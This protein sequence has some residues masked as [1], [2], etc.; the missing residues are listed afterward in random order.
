MIDQLRLASDAE[1]FHAA[2]A[3]IERWPIAFIA[4]PRD[5]YEGSWKTISSKAVEFMQTSPTF[6]S[7][8]ED[9]ERV[10]ALTCL[11]QGN[12][13]TT[14]LLPMAFREAIRRSTSFEQAFGYLQKYEF[15]PFAVLQ[16][17][18][19]VLIE[20]QATT[21]AH[22]NRL[23]DWMEHHVEH[24]LEEPE[25]L[26]LAEL[27]SALPSFATREE[28]SAF[29]M[30][31]LST[32]RTDQRLQ[33]YLA[34][35]WWDHLPQ[36]GA[37]IGFQELTRLAF[38]GQLNRNSAFWQR[39]I[40]EATQPIPIVAG[41]TIAF[42]AWY[43]T[44]YRLSPATIY[45][46]LRS[47]ALEGSEGLF[48]SAESRR[49]LLQELMH[50]YLQVDQENPT[51]QQVAQTV[52]DTLAEDPSAE[53]FFYF[54]GPTL[55]ELAFQVPQSPYSTDALVEFLLQHYLGAAKDIFKDDRR[56]Q[57]S[58][59]AEEFKPTQ[60]LL[61]LRL[62]GLVTGIPPKL[63]TNRMGQHSIQFPPR[64]VE[65]VEEF[66][67]QRLEHQG[68]FE[69]RRVLS[70]RVAPM[71]LAVLLAEQSGALGVRLL[72]LVG[73]YMS[74]SEEDRQIIAQVYDKV[75]G[76]SKLQAFRVI[77][78]EAK[79]HPALQA[80]LDQLSELQ[81]MIG[82]GSIVTVYK[83][84]D[85]HGQPWAVGVKNPNAE[86]RAWELTQFANQIVDGLVARSQDNPTFQD[87]LQLI[88]V[89]L[90]DAYEW[91]EAEIND[92][93]Y[94]AKN[95]RF[96]Q[97]HDA[98]S[99]STHRF[100]PLPGLGWN[101]LVPRIRNTETDFVRWEEF[102]E[103]ADLI[104]Y[105]TPGEGHPQLPED[106]KQAIVGVIAQDTIYQVLSGLAHSDLHGGQLRDAGQQHLAI[107]DRKNLL[108][109]NQEERQFLMR[110][111]QAMALGNFQSV[112]DQMA[113]RFLGERAGDA[114]LRTRLQER[115]TSTLDPNE[116]ERTIA[117][118][119]ITLKQEGMAVPLKWLLLVK[120]FLALNQ[121]SQWAGFGHF[122]NAV[123]YSPTSPTQHVAA[124]EV[125]Q[126]LVLPA[127]AVPDTGEVGAVTTMSVSSQ[128]QPHEPMAGPG[129]GTIL[130]QPNRL[131][132]RGDQLAEE[133]RIAE[134][135]EAWQKAIHGDDENGVLGY[136]DMI[137]SAGS[138][139]IIE[140]AKRNK[141]LAERRVETATLVQ[142][143]T[144]AD[145][146]APVL[147]Q[148]VDSLDQS[149]VILIGSESLTHIAGVTTLLRLRHSPHVQL[150]YVHTD[151]ATATP[152]AFLDDHGIPSVVFDAIVNAKD[153]PPA[154]MRKQILNQLAAHQGPPGLSPKNT[155]T[156]AA[157]PTEQKLFAQ[158]TPA[159]HMSLGQPN[160]ALQEVPDV[161]TAMTSALLVI[162]TPAP[163]AMPVPA[164]SP[165]TLQPAVAEAEAATDG[166]RAA[167]IPPVHNSVL[168]DLDASY[169]S[170]QAVTRAG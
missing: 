53:D 72:Q 69:H 56:P 26:M 89:L 119:L 63:V 146:M 57:R 15:L 94:I 154:T 99:T 33:E 112:V 82:G 126:R 58:I 59:A 31:A 23:S 160:T 153:A 76:Q 75:R 101:L 16:D 46:L 170:R 78:R 90:G 86:Y 19:E 29:W 81:Q 168:A 117:T 159:L 137:A 18:L 62:K 166:I 134:A 144:S 11:A 133:G 107:F 87:T 79:E 152:E 114:A 98:R 141:A 145:P 36:R 155:V 100:Q 12:F 120:D 158:L 156:I 125:L 83:G 20:E 66:M 121:M 163:H 71:K 39:A 7:S 47:L 92:A 129:G 149:V 73:L 157:T 104:R 161:A 21:P 48:R 128:Q 34:R 77:Q 40:I 1:L 138:G 148:A 108:T 105:M 32:N 3:S 4:I 122:L 139:E 96:A 132:Q 74:L 38:Y 28:K 84:V 130:E 140:A 55:T 9:F 52:I 6:P 124:F 85:T 136:D 24:L 64:T 22:L 14:N 27:T 115:V 49:A 43:A 97:L 116:P 45:M 8:G 2:A 162:N 135:I 17:G 42:E 123:S 80:L 60:Q 164:T 110:M 37:E 147:D 169:R 142:D 41:Y 13:Q 131:L 93:D 106:Q 61:G 70:D 111:F 91:I 65:T 25:N 54:L 35:R 102:V 30:A 109:F 44:L 5:R 103:G 68:L 10:L 165:E 50:D 127:L 143:A 95:Q 151:A 88:K 51:V 167:Y 113:T 150:V 67:M 118:L